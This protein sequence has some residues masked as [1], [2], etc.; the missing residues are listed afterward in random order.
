M[1]KG[2]AK[3]GYKSGIL[4]VARS[5][6]KYPTT[7]QQLA[8]EKTQPTISKGPKGVGYADGIMHPNGSSRFPKPTKFVNVEQM[9]QESI[10]TPTVVPE[11]I[12]D[13]K[14]SQMKKAELRRTY[15]AEALRLEERRLLKRE[16]L[17]RERTKL[18]E[19]EMEKRKALTMQSKSSDLTVPSLEHILN[20]PLVVPRTQEEKKILSMK[21]QYN[22]E[23]NELKGKENKLEKLLKLYYELDDYIVTEEQL[24]QKINEIFERKSYPIL[25]LL[26]VQ[27]DVKQQQL[28]DKIS[29]ALFGSIDTKHPGLPMVEDYLNNNTKKFAEAVELT[30]QILKKQTADQ[31]DQIPEK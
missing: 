4:P 6:L 5:V 13:K 15:L 16:R 21:R 23:L 26:D 12:S 28:E 10:H 14:L 20:Q 8:I 31:L 11:N 29:D 19:L 25:S 9:I 30:K 27:D 18:L 2:I 3:Y 17:I 1:G 22:R 7:K 24:I